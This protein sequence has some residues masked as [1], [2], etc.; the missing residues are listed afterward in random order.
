MNPSPFKDDSPKK[1]H[2]DDSDSQLSHA[3]DQ[4]KHY[5][6]K[7]KDKYSDFMDDVKNDPKLAEAVNLAKTHRKETFFI[8]LMGLGILISFF[9][10]FGGMLVGVVST[11]CLPWDLTFV[12]K[13]ASEFY[14]AKGQFKSVIMGLLALYLL[15]HAPSLIIGSVV[16]LGLNLFFKQDHDN[17]D[18]DS[19]EDGGKAHKGK[20]LSNKSKKDDRLP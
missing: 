10:Y 19:E 17:K 11:L 13:K 3:A 4:A 14:D 18:D 7:A 5:W 8:I 20:A 6:H 1:K 2:S 15:L 16:G 12:W 9:S